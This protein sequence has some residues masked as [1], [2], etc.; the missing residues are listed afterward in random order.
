VVKCG[1]IDTETTGTDHWHGCL[2]FMVTAT[3][4][5]ANYYW[6]GKVNPFNRAEVIWKP[7]IIKQIQ[8]F[9]DSCD[10][11]PFHNAKF[12]IRMLSLIGITIPWQKVVDTVV[13]SHL[14]CSGEYRRLKL[15]AYKYLG[16]KNEEELLLGRNVQ[17]E[18]A[19]HPE[20]DIA[21]R[22]HPCFPALKG[23]GVSWYKMD[24][25]LRYADCVKYGLADSEMTWMLWQMYDDH[26]CHN[27]LLEQFSNRM[28]LLRISYRMEE[29]GYHLYVD[30]TLE[31]IESLKKREEFLRLKIQSDYK[32][33]FKL[34]LGRR[35]HL[36]FMFFNVLKLPILEESEK[37]GEPS[38][39][40]VNID[41]YIA[42]GKAQEHSGKVFETSFL[43]DFSE[44]KTVRKQRGSLEGYVEWTTDDSRVHPNILITGTRETRQSVKQPAIQTLDK[45]LRHIWGPEKGKVWLHYDLVNIELRIWGYAVGNKEMVEIFNNKQSFHG[46]ICKLLYPDEW[47]QCIDQET[48]FKTKYMETLYQWVKNGNFSIIYNAGKAKADL[49]YRLKGAYNQVI[50]RFPEV[51]V[52]AQSVI[53]EVYDNYRKYRYP[54][55]YTLGGYPLD[56][57]LDEIHTTACNYKSQGSAGYIMNLSQIEVDKNPDYHSSLSEMINQGHDSLTI[58]TP[59]ENLTTQLT[60]SIKRSIEIG[61]EKLIPTCEAELEKVIYHPDDKENIVV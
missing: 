58:E 55:L 3:E 42:R 32:L 48:P 13:A 35:S 21:V 54:F 47:A 45:R 39:S 29:V 5:K 22:G 30:D 17:R 20:Y 33:G 56:I 36:K 43:Q 15:L 14:A 12:D 57:N 50:H 27:N 52:Y 8:A 37:T 1:A 9:V 38:L 49:T 28:E 25:W 24:Y 16:Y 19:Q 10:I 11:L 40:A 6:C 31:E 61:G 60:E 18:R 4:G 7:S 44:H 59:I 26:L 2:P 41:S 23:Q 46:V 34:D 51:P 53:D